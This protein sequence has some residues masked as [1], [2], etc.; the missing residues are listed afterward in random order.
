MSSSVERHT[1]TGFGNENLDNFSLSQLMVGEAVTCF[2]NNLTFST[3]STLRRTEY[4]SIKPRDFQL[5]GLRAP[6]T[7]KPICFSSQQAMHF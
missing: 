6:R 7:L 3:G 4:R 5:F 2:S 1:A